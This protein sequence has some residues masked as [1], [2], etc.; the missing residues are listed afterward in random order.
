MNADKDFARRVTLS[1]ADVVAGFRVATT[2]EYYDHA[3][4]TFST[5]E[6]TIVV[7]YD[8]V[9]DYQEGYAYGL[10]QDSAGADRHILFLAGGIH[11]RAGAPLTNS[12]NNLL[13]GYIHGKHRREMGSDCPAALT[14]AA[15]CG[16]SDH[17]PKPI[18][19]EVRKGRAIGEENHEKWVS[20][21]GMIDAQQLTWSVPSVGKSLGEVAGA[22]LREILASK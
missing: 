21:R 17:F 4:E 12:P 16:R 7:G 20:M 18:A 19:K 14:F 3:S 1:P 11:D 5:G 2:R 13:Y 8:Y 10:K 9:A 22:A 6:C 15:K